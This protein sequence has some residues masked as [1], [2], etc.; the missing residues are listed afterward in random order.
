MNQRLIFVHFLF[1]KQVG[2]LKILTWKSWN[3]PAEE[4][5]ASKGDLQGTQKELDA[6][7]AYFDKLK[8]VPGWRDELL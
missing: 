4:L 6:A 7:N 8:P 5:T 2:G 1:S 3:H